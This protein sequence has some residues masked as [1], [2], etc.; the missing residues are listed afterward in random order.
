MD[1]LMA[2]AQRALE[3]FNYGRALRLFR[4]ALETGPRS[5]FI[6]GG[7]A[8]SLLGLRRYGEAEKYCKE[9]ISAEPE[10]SLPHVLM[11]R[12]LAGLKDV[13]AGEREAHLALQLNGRSGDAAALLSFFLL[14]AGKVDDTISLLEQATS[15]PFQWLEL[16]LVLYQNLGVAYFRKKDFKGYYSCRKKCYQLKPS[17]HSLTTLVI[18]FEYLHQTL[19]RIVF[20][21][22]LMLT[23]FLQ[24]RLLI[25]IPILIL[26]P[27]VTNMIFS[28]RSKSWERVKSDFGY[29]LIMGILLGMVYYII[30]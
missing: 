14:S 3:K 27:R 15:A 10:A 19:V 17:L 20:F 13:E 2:S 23:I 18:S 7:I 1:D 4:A 8:Q 24:Q 11:S 5:D 12:A 16:K 22:S 30:G 6:I 21:I 9:L 26:I 25:L 29:L 28:I